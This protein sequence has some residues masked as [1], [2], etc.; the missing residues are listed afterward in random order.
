MKVKDIISHMVDNYYKVVV[1]A[2]DSDTHLI[3]ERFIIKPHAAD[4][5]NIPENIWNSEVEMI[6]VHYDS[7]VI[8]V[9]N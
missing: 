5:S 1:E 4:Y 8:D 9:K 6:V 3:K 7:L 2:F